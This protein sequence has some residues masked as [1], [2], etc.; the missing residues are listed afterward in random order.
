MS[1][2]AGVS[3][4]V[5]KLYDDVSFVC[6]RCLLTGCR[7]SDVQVSFMTHLDVKR[8]KVALNSLHY[9]GII[10][11]SKGGWMFDNSESRK[12]CLNRLK[13]IRDKL[14]EKKREEDDFRCE[15]CDF[16][17][18]ASDLS[19]D[20]LKCRICSSDLVQNDRCSDLLDEAEYLIDALAR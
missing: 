20:H 4:L 8:V 17:C 11:A 3:L 1:E 2:L 10:E 16:V 7:L 5:R 18:S 15:K 9:T 6:F 12:R 14:K 19:F 13:S